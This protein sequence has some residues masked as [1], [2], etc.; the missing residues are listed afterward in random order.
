M[1]HEK[2]DQTFRKRYAVNMSPTGLFFH[3]VG[4][5]LSRKLTDIGLISNLFGPVVM[6]YWEKLKPMVEDARKQ[7][8]S[9]GFGGGVEYLYIELKKREQKLQSKA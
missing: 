4:I 7:L 8:N 2:S 3:E 5:L 9:P 1:G 6:G